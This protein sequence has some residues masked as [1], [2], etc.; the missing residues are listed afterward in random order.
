MT[1]LDNRWSFPVMLPPLFAQTEMCGDGCLGW[2]RTRLSLSRHFRKNRIEKAQQRT[3][4]SVAAMSGSGRSLLEVKGLES[5]HLPYLLSLSSQIVGIDYL[6][7]PSYLLS[8]HPH[9][10]HSHTT[11]SRSSRFTLLH[12]V[13]DSLTCG[14]GLNISI[15]TVITKT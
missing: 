6:I 15:V 13:P 3:Y 9:P 7:Y 8:P 2:R 1:K 10:W 12:Q 14:S 5:S 11:L 4:S